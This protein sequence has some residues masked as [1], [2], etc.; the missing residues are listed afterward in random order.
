MTDREQLIGQGARILREAM[1]AG[2]ISIATHEEVEVL[3][4]AG[5]R[6]SPPGGVIEDAA[7]ALHEYMQPSQDCCEPGPAGVCLACELKVGLLAGHGFIATQEDCGWKQRYE[8]LRN[9]TLRD[10]CTCGDY[11]PH[12]RGS[13]QCVHPPEPFEES[14]AIP[15]LPPDEV[16]IFLRWLVS[17]DDPADSDAMESRRTVTLTKIIASARVALRAAGEGQHG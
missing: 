7:R 6:P 3:F 8:A 4:D 5:W 17:L 13:Q 9:E 15:V 12:E 10:V 16:L 2:R 14:V 11:P 1:Q